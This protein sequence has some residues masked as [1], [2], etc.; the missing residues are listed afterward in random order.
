MDKHKVRSLVPC[1]GWDGNRAQV[2]KQPIDSIQTYME[3]ID[4]FI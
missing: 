1:C 3:D 4:T 2:P